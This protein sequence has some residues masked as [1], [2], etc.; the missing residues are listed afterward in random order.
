MK[1]DNKAK[2]TSKTKILNRPGNENEKKS[3]EINIGDNVESDGAT[4]KAQQLKCG[5]ANKEKEKANM[6]GYDKNKLITEEQTQGVNII[7]DNDN[8]KATPNLTNA[9]DSYTT[10]IVQPKNNINI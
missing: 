10:H 5:N 4:R 9:H 2:N 6:I 3:M 8:N 1:F 7:Q